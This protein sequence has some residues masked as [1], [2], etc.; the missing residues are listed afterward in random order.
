MAAA[1]AGAATSGKLYACYSDKTKA[2]Y[3][4]KPGTKCAKGFTQISWNKQGPQG[5]QGAQGSPGPQGP[6]GAVTG[7]TDAKSGA[8]ISL[9]A[10]SSGGGVP[11]TVA[12][13]LPSAA[14]SYAVNAMALESGNGGYV[15]CYDR[16]LSSQGASGGATAI[17]SATAA[18]FATLPTNGILHAGPT[19][20]ILEICRVTD[21]KPPQHG[22][23]ET[24]QLTAVQL[25]TA[26]KSGSLKP[27]NRFSLPKLR[28]AK[29]K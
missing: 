26:H 5:A 16:A 7:Y 25:S 2:L 9:P 1:P 12:S 20:P 29:S 27:A 17:A 28:R 3:Y 18:G 22:R 6:A 15:R 13:V 23:V 10:T 19:L 11:V 24:A 4:S 21:L 14:G 8:A